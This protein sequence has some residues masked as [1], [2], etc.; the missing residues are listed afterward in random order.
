MGIVEVMVHP[1]LEADGQL[2]D[3]DGRG[4]AVKLADIGIAPNTFAAHPEKGCQLMRPR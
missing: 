1:R 4:L 3:A 2:V